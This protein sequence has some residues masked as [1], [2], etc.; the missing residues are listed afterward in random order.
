MQNTFCMLA[1]EECCTK[2]CLASFYCWTIPIRSKNIENGAVI[3]FCVTTYG[4]T[5]C[6][7]C[8]L[9][10]F[11]LNCYKVNS[12]KENLSGN[13]THI[14]YRNQ[15]RCVPSKCMYIVYHKPL[16]IQSSFERSRLLKYN[17]I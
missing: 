5:I 14:F 13:G 7:L 12:C 3:Q 17:C 2:N 10:E 4:V 16:Q 8:S 11:V 1:I 6:S 15:Q 9:L